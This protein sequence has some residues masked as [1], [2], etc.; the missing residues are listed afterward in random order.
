MSDPVYRAELTPVSFLRR[1]AAVFPDKT[2]VVHGER[3]S[4]YREFEER[5]NRLASRLRAAGLARHDRVAFL[6]PNTP[7]LLEAHFAVPAAGGVLVAINTRLSSDEIGYTLRHSEARFLFVDA[8]LEHLIQPLDTTGIARVRIDDTGAPGDPYEDFLA[9]GTPEPVESWL[10]DELETISINYTSG[11]TGRPKGVMYT[12]RGAYLNALGQTIEMGMGAGSVFLWVLP[13][14]HCNGWCLPWAVTAV[15]GTHVCLRRFDPGQVWDLFA[16][17]GVTHYSGAPTVHI[18]M[19]NDPKARPLDQRITL[20]SGGSPPSPTLLAQLTELNLRPIHVYG[21]TETYGP[22]TVS[23]WQSEWGALPLE[24]QTR[25]LA[26]QGHAN[27]VAEPV[28]VVDDDMRD[29][30]R[31]GET[32]GEVVMRGNLVMAGYFADPDATAEAFRGGW[33]HSGDL[34]V[35]HADGSIELRDRK[36]DIV[37]SGGEN[38]STI[39][40]EQTLA[41]HP[42][43]LE[44]AVIGIPD[45]KWGERPKAFVALKPGHSVGAEELIAFCREHLAHFKCPAAVEFG[46]LP[47]TSTGKVQKVVLRD[48]AWAAHAHR[49]H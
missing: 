22:T 42:A 29:V 4:S 27:V 7:A 15:G 45:D 20:T 33:F 9:A 24:S 2:A 16:A 37:I 6:C 26:R 18:G 28:R 30:P 39:E 13:M 3:R 34:G 14:F 31:D 36:K 10:E 8:E 17:E 35:M 47:K 49:I 43:V 40:V 21:L 12:Y 23:R 38:I 1:S 44:S 5:V 25:R 48:R 19:V 46:G 41:R 11:T 32:L